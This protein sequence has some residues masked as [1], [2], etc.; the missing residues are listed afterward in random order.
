[1]PKLVNSPPT[2]GLIPLIGFISFSKYI[3]SL[4]IIKYTRRLWS[5]IVEIVGPATAIVTVII[6]ASLCL[7]LLLPYNRKL[8]L[9]E[10]TSPSLVIQRRLP[11]IPDI[12][13]DLLD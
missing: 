9:D 8:R 4:N 10:K 13:K 3:F 6:G 7:I 12:F 5:N 2:G 11:N 1:M